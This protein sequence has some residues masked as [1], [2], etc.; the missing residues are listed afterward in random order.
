VVYEAPPAYL[1][2]GFTDLT[3]GVFQTCYDADDCN[4]DTANW[5]LD[6]TAPAG[7]T[8]LPPSSVPEPSSAPAA[9]IG[10]AVGASVYARSRRLNKGGN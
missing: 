2:D 3:A 1:G 4:M 5:A 7:S 8:I 9:A 6:I 10:L